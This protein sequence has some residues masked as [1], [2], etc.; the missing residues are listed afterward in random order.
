MCV[1]VCTRVCGCQKIPPGVEVTGSWVTQCGYWKW[2]SDPLECT[3]FARIA[4]AINH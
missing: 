1:Y 3:S 4:R 2:K